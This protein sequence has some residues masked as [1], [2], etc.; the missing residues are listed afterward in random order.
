M[1]SFI[2]YIYVF[3]RY[4]LNKNLDL[5]GSV[6]YALGQSFYKYL[7]KTYIYINCVKS[8]E[9]I[10]LAVVV[11]KLDVTQLKPPTKRNTIYLVVQSRG[12]N[13]LP[14][15]SFNGSDHKSQS[16]GACVVLRDHM[17]QTFPTTVRK[18]QRG[19]KKTT[20]LEIFSFLKFLIFIIII[21]IIFIII[22]VVTVIISNILL[23]LPQLES[24][25]V[26]YHS[27]CL[28]FLLLFL[29]VITF[30]FEYDL[31]NFLLPGNI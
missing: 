5:H 3:R 2:I 25:R 31:M 29:L 8:K 26:S 11:I 18:V 24:L 22:V 23:V 1:G 19:W 16:L 10:L 28:L 13:P 17:L 9:Y 6:I 15:A 27:Y 4:L 7:R 12:L 20:P 14:L 21:I 30:P